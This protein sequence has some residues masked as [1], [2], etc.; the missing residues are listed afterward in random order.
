MSGAVNYLGKLTGARIF[1]NE[2][3]GFTDGEVATIMDDIHARGDRLMMGFLSC[4]AVLAIFLAYSFDTWLLSICISFLAMTMFHVSVKL[5]PGRLLTRC[6]SGVSLQTFVALHIYQQH[7][8]PEMHFFFFTAFT[9][10]LVY[11]DWICMWP[12]ALLI[13]GQHILFAILHNAGAPLFFFTESYVGF[14]KLFFHFGIAIVHV[15]ICGSWAVLIKR[16]TLQF[17]RQEAQLREAKEKAEESTKAKS[18]LLAM[19][20]HEIRTPMNAVMGMTQLMMSTDLSGEQRDYAD[21]TRRGV[22]ALLSVI[23]DLL[24]FSK[25]EARKINIVSNPFNLRALL[26]DVVKFLIVGAREKGLNLNLSYPSGL[27]DYFSGDENRIRQIAMNLVGNAIKFTEQGSVDVSVTI[28]NVRNENAILIGVKDTGMGV[29]EA[30]QPLLFQEFSQLDRGTTRKHGG[31]GLG[32]AISKKLC[33]LMGGEIGVESSEGDGSLFWFRLTLPS[34]AAFEE[35]PCE[36]LANIENGSNAHVLLVEDNAVNLRVA[37]AFLQK[38]GCTITTAKDGMEAVR[39]WRENRFD[40]IFMDCQMPEMDGYAA[41]RN[42]RTLEMSVGQRTPIIAM[43]AY[44]MTGDREDCLASGMDDYLTKPLDIRE[45]K[46]ALQR[47]MPTRV[48]GAKVI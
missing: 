30:L 21:S 41:T 19:M 29:P 22:N 45:L 15:A 20:S 32:L 28:Q 11:Q 39:F 42:I 34:A 14:K 37:S 40:I 26:L 23:N 18:S 16:Q 4:H 3:F 36:L 6:I 24:D 9:M 12:G 27:P 10:M 47:W 46:A 31:T 1:P 5:L 33:E 48:Y 17:A 38:L 8:M 13:I 43:T 7:G 25:I 44:A 2:S 35:Q